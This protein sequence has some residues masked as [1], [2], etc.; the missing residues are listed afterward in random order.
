MSENNTKPTAQM[1]RIFPEEMERQFYKILVRDGMNADKAT[2]CA[3]VF[4]E[5][6]VDGVYTHGVNRFPRFV[7]YIKD[8]HVITEAEPVLKNTLGA[9]EQWDGQS[10]P[11]ITNALFCTDRVMEVA[12]KSGIGCVAIGNTNHW[13][14]GGTYGWKAAKEGFAFICWTNTIAN[15]PAW[16]AQQNRLGNNPLI[17]AV[18]YEDE[19]IVLDMAIS[20]FSFGKIELMKMQGEKLPVAGGFDKSGD[21]STDPVAIMDSSLLLPVGYWKGSGLSLLLDILAAILSGGLA[22]NE[23]SKL[24]AET[25]VSQVFIAIDL[26]KLQ[27]TSAISQT[28]Q[29]IIQDYKSATALPGKSVRYPGEGVVKTRKENLERGIPVNLKVWNEIMGL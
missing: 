5:N 2:T 12:R 8:K 28:L 10:G 3:R 17:F 22:T 23:I 26:S 19:A 4:T 1:R 24:P 29:E 16:G 15:M 20:Q 14:R 9:V 25:N 7:Q 13:M 18:P 11:G 6:S 21:L 27:S